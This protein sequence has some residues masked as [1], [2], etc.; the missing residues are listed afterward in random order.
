MPIGVSYDVPASYV[1]F[2]AVKAIAYT[3]YAVVLERWL[4]ST[5]AGPV[6]NVLLV[7][8]SRTLLGMAVGGAYL[9]LCLSLFTARCDESHVT[10][11]MSLL[12][13]RVFEWWLIL[14]LFYKP[15]RPRRVFIVAIVLGIIVSYLADIPAVFG[16]LCTG[17]LW[18]C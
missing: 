11:W 1:T 8:I 10:Y 6:V 4:G 3:G 12:P 13:I 2:A 18:V 16:W 9:Y 5:R 15:E 17:G 14:R 7:G